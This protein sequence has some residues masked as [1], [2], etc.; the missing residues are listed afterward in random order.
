MRDGHVEWRTIHQGK[1]G[2]EDC[3]SLDFHSSPSC[4][5]NQCLCVLLP[6]SQYSWGSRHSM[7]RGAVPLAHMLCTA[8]LS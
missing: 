4:E 5:E 2:H 1:W 7:Q 3:P 8:Q 6:P